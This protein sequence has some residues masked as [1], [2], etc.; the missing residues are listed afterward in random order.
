VIEAENARRDVLSSL[1]TV[2]T[3]EVKSRTNILDELK[4]R[5]IWPLGEK[6]NRK[7]SPPGKAADELAL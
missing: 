1:L 2:G 3:S 6:T 5:R 7:A 4:A